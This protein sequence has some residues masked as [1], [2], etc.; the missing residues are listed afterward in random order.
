M[1]PA[2]I[3]EHMQNDVVNIMSVVILELLLLARDYNQHKGPS[4][5]YWLSCGM[6]WNTINLLKSQ[7]AFQVQ[8][9][10]NH[11]E[12]LRKINK[13]QDSVHSIFPLYKMSR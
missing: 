6:Q 8:M 13:A 9:K 12:L 4:M 5:E 2:E 10:N 11:H 7:E 3:P 1:H